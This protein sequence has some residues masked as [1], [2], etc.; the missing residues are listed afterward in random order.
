ME[1]AIQHGDVPRAGIDQVL[2]RLLGH[3]AGADHQHPLIVEPLEDS[4]GEIGDRH[5]GDADAMAVERGFAG[6]AAGHAE[7]GLEQAV[8]QRAGA[9]DLPGLLV[10]LLDLGQNL[11]FADDHAIKTGGDPK[12]VVDRLR[13]FQGYQLAAQLLDRHVV[14]IGQVR[15]EHRRGEGDAGV[16]AGGVE[17]NPMASGEEDSLAGGVG[18]ARRPARRAF[19]PA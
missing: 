13:V 1:V 12:Q 19:A 6:H 3:L 11:R 10:G 18:R 15:G 9:A 14:K 16:I 8:R 17:L 5:A 7:R 4:R 2:Q